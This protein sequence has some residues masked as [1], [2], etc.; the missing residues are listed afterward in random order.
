MTEM[1]IGVKTH[2]DLSPIS[3]FYQSRNINRAYGHS[4]KALGRLV[5]R[6]SQQM[7]AEVKHG[8][9]VGSFPIVQDTI[10]VVERICKMNQYLKECLTSCNVP[11]Q[12]GVTQS[13][14]V[15][16]STVLIIISADIV[17]MYMSLTKAFILSTIDEYLLARTQRPSATP[18]QK[19]AAEVFRSTY[20][21][22]TIFL[23]ENFFL[24]IQSNGSKIFYRQADGL[25]MGAE[26]SDSLSSLAVILKE[27][28][29]YKKVIVMLKSF[30]AELLDKIRFVD[31]SLLVVL[32]E[33]QHEQEI[34][35]K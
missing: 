21:Q 17:N 20:M 16:N 2:K 22:L 32:A 13:Y 30:G 7:M 34:T 3:S 1:S 5:K 11:P 18:E 23:L 12:V 33:A 35:K 31:D 19:T 28:I 29:M 9:E 14:R 15:T 24:Y 27:A 26:Y 6:M 8:W 25:P 10:T 4:L